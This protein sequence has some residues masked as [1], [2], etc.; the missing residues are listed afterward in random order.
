MAFVTSTNLDYLTTDLRIHI[1]DYTVP[2]VYSDE[3]LFTLL[4]TAVKKLAKRWASKY[5]IDANDDVYRNTLSTLE[6]QFASPPIIQQIDEWPIV[7]AASITLGLGILKSTASS[8][9]SWRDDE[10]SFSNLSSGKMVED[11]VLRDIEELDQ[12]VAPPS[13]KLASTRRQGLPGFDLQA[14]EGGFAV[15]NSSGSVRPIS[16]V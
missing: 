16:D 11:W 5:L 6:W 15:P 12:I 13:K 7:L 4:V 2:Y 9:V 14:Y 10:V 8:L 3:L 1:S